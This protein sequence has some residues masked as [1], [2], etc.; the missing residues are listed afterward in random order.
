MNP[1]ADVLSTPI[2]VVLMCE[3]PVVYRSLGPRLSADRALHV[4]GTFDCVMDKVAEVAGMNPDVVVLG[5]SRITH[6]N[7]MIVTAIKQ[8]TPDVLVIIL[9]SYVDDTDEV[10]SARSAGADS[11]MIK[12]I[13]TPALVQQIHTLFELKS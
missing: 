11:V 5:I 6:F 8:I 2:R 4:I 1:R 7:M 9:P 3:N 13:D 10:R 12:S